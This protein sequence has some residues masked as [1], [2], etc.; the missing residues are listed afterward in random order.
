MK[1]PPWG[2]VVGKQAPSKKAGRRPVT[3]RIA[4]VAALAFAPLAGA[5]AQTPL[6]GINRDAW[7]VPFPTQPADTFVRKGV[8]A[9]SLVT[10]AQCE[11]SGASV[12]GRFV[13]V[14]AMGRGACIRYFL[15]ADSF[16][17]KAAAVYL[18]GDKGSFRI[19]WREGRYEM[20]P[21]ELLPRAGEA[22]KP[23]AEPDMTRV[24]GDPERI[25][26]SARALA[27][28]LNMPAIV[29][30]RQG[31]DGS[32][33]WV[34]LRRTRWEA[35]IT[36]LALDA[37]KARHGVARLHIAGQSGGG[38]LVGA[39]AATRSDIACAVAGSAPL[40]I[41]PS[42][43]Y[44]SEKLP[45]SQRFFN[46]VAHAAAIA[47]KPGLR[48]MLVTDGRD[49]RVFVESQAQ[50]VRALAKH[51]ARIP[52]HF[53]SAGDALSHGVTAYSILALRSCIAGKSDD[54]IGLDLA[55]MNTQALERRLQTAKE[56]AAKEQARK[57]QTGGKPGEP[58]DQEERTGAPTGLP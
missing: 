53:V 49:N 17:D 28:R 26:N 52:Q 56:R 10:R 4:L 45:E 13:Y 44:L 42:S 8:Q 32:S 38:H 35:E 31:T 57:P 9:G 1:A 51:G 14:E 55:R 50:F 58:A 36:S 37:I 6:P 12:R 18:P 16:P 48:L 2:N 21:E 23:P 40:S 7:L 34:A 22:A 54:E 20:I 24:L 30:S 25:Q 33:G 47:K 15:S 41:N 3:T 39:L 27:S 29:I 11:A 5:L 43:F 46:P 19:A